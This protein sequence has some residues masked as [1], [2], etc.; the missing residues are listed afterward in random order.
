M[1]EL[2]LS[3]QRYVSNI[4]RSKTG[5]T[6]QHFDPVLVEYYEQPRRQSANHFNT[7][8]FLQFVPQGKLGDPDVYSTT[9]LPNTI[10]ADIFV[11][12]EQKTLRLLRTELLFG[13][14]FSIEYYSE[15]CQKIEERLELYGYRFRLTKCAYC[16]VFVIENDICFLVFPTEKT[17]IASLDK[18][19]LCS[20]SDATIQYAI[21]RDGVVYFDGWIRTLV[22][23]SEQMVIATQE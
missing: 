10:G 20:E 18:R 9:I 14:A 23:K 11:A 19:V 8:F 2:F 21:D 12:V 3:E 4:I 7:D 16:R 13:D 5:V 1:R 17:P 22:I 6:L 15:F